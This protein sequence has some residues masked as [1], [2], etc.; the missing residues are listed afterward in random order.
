MAASSKSS[1]LSVRSSSRY[2]GYF[3]DAGGEIHYAPDRW[4]HHADIVCAD[5]WLR[6]AVLTAVDEQPELFFHEIADSVNYLAEK[7]GAGEEVSA[8]TVGRILA[9]NVL[10]R[11]VIERAFSTRN[12]EQGALRVEAQWRTPLRCRVYVYEAHR[13][14]R[15]V[16]RRWAWSLRGWRAECYVEASP[17]VRASFSLLWPMTR[18]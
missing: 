2:L 12:E 10:T 16:E 5:P 17:G 14:G 18:F 1:G 9:R 11:K 13:V 6:A 15:A 8:V 4:N 7:V 3:C